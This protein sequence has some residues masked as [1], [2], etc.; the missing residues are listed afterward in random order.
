[1]RK[2]LQMRML[3]TI[4][5]RVRKSVDD[6]QL[7]RLTGAVERKQMTLKQ[8]NEQAKES[9]IN[10]GPQTVYQLRNDFF[11]VG[12]YEITQGPAPSSVRVSRW[13]DGK[14]VGN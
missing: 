11:V 13:V 10:W 12:D 14:S 4:G 9:S 8:A 6:A 1:M 5:L 2:P 3:Q 7:L